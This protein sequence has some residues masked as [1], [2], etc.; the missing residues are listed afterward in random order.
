MMQI[1]SETMQVA[2]NETSWNTITDIIKIII[3]EI[4][5]KWIINQPTMIFLLIICIKNE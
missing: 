5:K 3:K 2:A 1:R 4:F